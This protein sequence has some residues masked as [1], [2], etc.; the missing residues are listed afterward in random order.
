MHAPISV[1]GGSVLVLVTRTGVNAVLAGLFLG[2][3]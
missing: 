3:N 1:A 2:G